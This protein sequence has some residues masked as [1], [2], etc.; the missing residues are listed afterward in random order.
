MGYLVD[1]EHV[2]T[3]RMIMSVVLLVKSA[4]KQYNM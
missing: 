1:M 3:A 4:M 2:Q